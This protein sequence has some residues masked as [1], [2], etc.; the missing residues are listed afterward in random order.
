MIQSAVIGKIEIIGE[1]AKNL[2]GAFKSKYNFV[3]WRNIAGM[4]DKLI[5]GYFGVDVESVWEV[6]QKDLPF[7][8]IF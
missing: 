4:R 6:A 7:L 8:S 1:T 2:E 3:L 5:Y